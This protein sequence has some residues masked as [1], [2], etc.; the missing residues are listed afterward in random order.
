MFTVIGYTYDG[1]AYGVSVDPDRNPD[2]QFGIVDGSPNVVGLLLAHTGRSV[3]VT[4]TGPLV[5]VDMAD[6]NT[7][8]SALYSLTQV[9]SVEGDGVPDALPDPVEGRSY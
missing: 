5:V 2:P 3:L 7:V 9:I 1:A 6:A 8:L 4:P